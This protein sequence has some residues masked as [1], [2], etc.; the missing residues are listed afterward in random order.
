MKVFRLW[1]VF[2]R[3]YCSS[4]YDHFWGGYD[5][6]RSTF[7]LRT[8]GDICP[9]GFYC[10]E[11]SD[12]PTPCPQGTYSDQTGL[13]NVTDC[14]L[15]DGGE[16]CASY[17]LTEPT[18]NCTRGMWHLQSVIFLLTFRIIHGAIDYLSISAEMVLLVWNEDNSYMSK[19]RDT[20]TQYWAVNKI[21]I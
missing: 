20:A 5:S 2:V 19:V 8:K 1:S 17:N 7:L 4:S 13:R 11:G 9:A 16:F 12:W 14:F 18:G 10:E 21:L 6:I 15:C 3:F